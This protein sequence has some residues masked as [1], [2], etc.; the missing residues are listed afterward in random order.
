MLL[1]I[2]IINSIGFSCSKGATVNSSK[3][4]QLPVRQGM[5]CSPMGD[6]RSYYRRKNN[7]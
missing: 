2:I 3:S 4:A 5:P 1:V 7:G 6:M